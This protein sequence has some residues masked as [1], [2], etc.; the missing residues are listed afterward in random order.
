[1][2]HVKVEYIRTK[3]GKEKKFSISVELPE[4][5]GEVTAKQF[6]AIFSVL[7]G[8]YPFPASHLTRVLLVKTLIFS[9]RNPIAR[10]RY[11]KA[12]QQLTPLQIVEVSNHIRF[13]WET[14]PPVALIRS[15]R[16]KFTR[17]YLPKDYL[18]NAIMLEYILADAYLEGIAEEK[19]LLNSELL[20]KLVATLARP[21][22][23]GWFFLK[24]TRHNNGDCRQRFNQNIMEQSAKRLA[25]LPARYKLFVLFFF[26]GCKQHIIEEYP[27]LFPKSKG[28]ADNEPYSWA[29][30]LK[31]VAATKLYGSYDETAYYNLHTI[32]TNL[33]FE[34]KRQLEWEAKNKK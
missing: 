14:S 23:F 33:Q 20:N 7:Y 21:K 6:K 29:E 9:H 4:H 3:K 27:L 18:E 34:R 22:K 10:Y 1:M 2:H 15:F 11:H 5:W 16:H 25:S 12:F 31:D 19:D 28:S 30:T 32:L 26:M 8:T 17:Y 13:L 24:H